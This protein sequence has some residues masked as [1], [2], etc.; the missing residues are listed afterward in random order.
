[1]KK[2][3]FLT[4][5]SLSINSCSLIENLS[6]NRKLLKKVYVNGELERE[7]YY[8]DDDQLI[9][10]T[11]YLNGSVASSEDEY[12]YMEN[13]TTIINRNIADN[14]IYRNRVY[15]KMN[16]GNVRYDRYDGN[17]DLLD[18]RIYSFTNRE[19]CG[20]TRIEKYDENGE[21][22]KT[23]EVSYSDNCSAVFEDFDA[24]GNPGFK[25]TYTRDGENI[26][27]ESTLL[28]ILNI[29][30]IG[31]LI[32]LKLEDG[33]GQPYTSISYTAEFEYED[34][35]PI[36]ETRTYLNGETGEYEYVYEE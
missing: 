7:Y 15:T 35:Y 14:S 21:L 22:D 11:F 8:N 4:L 17:N 29:G 32:E 12:T 31:N 24:L 28:E 3:I 10:S 23:T 18:S 27:Y 20:F 2:L 33:N 13:S 19:N 34:S 1:M 5:L 16:N 25:W 9:S 36:S 26:A 30:N 6:P